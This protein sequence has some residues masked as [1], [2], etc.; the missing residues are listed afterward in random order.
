MDTFINKHRDIITIKDTIYKSIND[1]HKYSMTK[2]ANNLKIFFIDDPKAHVSGAVMYVDV[3]H[4]HNPENLDGMAHYLEHMLF[5][6]SKKY[7]GSN[8]FQE[9]VSHTNGYTNAFT[10]EDCTQYFFSCN[11]DY[12][13]ILLDIFSYFFYKPI[14]DAKYVEKEISAVDSEHQKN[15]GNDGWRL[16]YLSKQFIKD[17]INSKFGTGTKQTLLGSCNNDPHILRHKLIDFFNRYYSSDKMVL[18]ISSN[19]IT[20]DFKEKVKLMFEKI[21][22]RKSVTIDRSISMKKLDNK[23]ELIKA[24]IN[25]KAHQLIIRWLVNGTVRYKNNICVDSFNMI[26]YLLSNQSNNSLYDILIKNQY[27]TDIH[28][29]VE[30][31]YHKNSIFIMCISLTDY[32]YN[33]WKNI[34][35][36]ISYYINNLKN[37]I[38]DDKLK[39]YY[40]EIQKLDVNSLK[41]MVKHNGFQIAQNLAEIYNSLKCDLRYLHIYKLLYSD[42][43]TRKKHFFDVMNGLTLNN[44]KIIL[45]SHLIDNTDKIDKFYGTKY[46]YTIEDINIYT[47]DIKHALP[48]QNTYISDKLNIY[49]P[50]D[51]FS[52]E[53]YKLSS[54]YDNIFYIKKSNKYNTYVSHGSIDIT[55]KSLMDRDTDNYI[56]LCLYVMYIQYVYNSDIYQMSVADININIDVTEYGIKIDINTIYGNLDSIFD[57]VF[58]W[59]YNTNNIDPYI[60]KLIYNKFY[61]YNNR[62]YNLEPH[63]CTSF[64][65]KFMLNNKYTIHV[66]KIL[67]KIDNY[68]PKQLNSPKKLAH[69][70]NISISLMS[71][72]S[73]IGVFGGSIKLNSVQRI[74][75]YIESYISYTNTKINYLI[76]HNCSTNKTVNNLNPNNSET[77][78]CCGIYLGNYPEDY[79][80]KWEIFKPICILLNNYISDK[81]SNLMRTENQLGYVAYTKLININEDDNAQLYLL[82]IIQ[83]NNTECKKLMYDYI[84]NILYNDI[85]SITEKQFNTLKNG[86]YMNLIEKKNNIIEELIQVMKTIKLTKLKHKNNNKFNRQKK[87]AQYLLKINLNIF[88]KFCNIYCLNPIIHCVEIKPS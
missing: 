73:I 67:K 66:D 16:M 32:G 26:D 19:N 78:I 69:F 68:S 35:Y 83:S 79:Y 36:T 76:K 37:N 59:I 2:T 23:Y 8:Y 88:L 53:Y 50:M 10:T 20:A 43:N 57:T 86:I 49:H 33:N 72:G 18:F 6:G 24:N 27:I 22:L 44:A 55:L 13:M 70:K 40:T 80:S 38:T 56:I 48:E 42:F 4:I 11:T 1:T 82:F 62:Y 77:S 3:G 71:L 54:I 60:Y 30:Q 84:Q 51:S 47:S 46:S 15:I 75:E 81:F 58:K 31:S 12:F 34:L 39:Q 45:G 74:I 29:G 25:D 87:M 9:K 85:K 41:T 7:P 5:M 21:P 63:K 14:F 65:F 64:D 28:T 17:K 61:I 52:N